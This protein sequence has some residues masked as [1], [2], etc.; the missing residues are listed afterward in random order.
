[1]FGFIAAPL[2]DPCS[3]V[4]DPRSG[5]FLPTLPIKAL[6]LDPMGL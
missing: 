3:G 2:P 4:P 6:G 5:D 1:M